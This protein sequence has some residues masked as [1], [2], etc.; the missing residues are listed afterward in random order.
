VTWHLETFE[1]LDAAGCT[2]VSDFLASQTRS[3]DA[4]LRGAIMRWKLLDNEVRPGFVSAMVTDHDD[5]V[6]SLCTVTPK[7]LWCDGAVQPWA[8]IGDTFTDDAFQRK[9]MFSALVNASRSRAQDAGF[10]IVYGEPNT[11][12]APGYLN[13]LAF[14]I[15]DNAG[16]L[17]CSLPLSARSIVPRLGARLPAAV[18]ARLLSAPAVALSRIASRALTW[19]PRRREVEVEPLVGGPGAISADFDRLWERVRAALP[20]AQVRDARYLAWRYRQHPLPFRIYTAREGGALRGWLVTM[21]AT[22]PPP[23]SEHRLSIVD[24][25]FAPDDAAGIGTALL[26]VAVREGVDGQ[27]DVVGAQTAI[28]TPLPLPWRRY[29]FVRRPLP[30][31]VI[32]HTSDAGRRFLERSE[33]WHYTLGDTD[34]F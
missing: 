8:E 27:A 18:A 12:S 7:R 16:L 3:R 22:D 20:I 17:N 4:A 15:K 28:A 23:L 10:G 13:K 25:L 6:V 29:G 19:R 11:Q 14:A 2:K 33:A 24:W 21:L 30:K 5:R 26:D 31:P 9:G 1:P 34:A 32:V